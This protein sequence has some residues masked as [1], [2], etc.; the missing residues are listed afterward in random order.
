[1]KIALAQL[2]SIDSIEHN[3][4]EIIRLT[5]EAFAQP[6]VDRPKI[7]FFP[8]NSLYFRIRSDEKLPQIFLDLKEIQVLE[9]LSRDTKIYLHFTSSIFDQGKNWNA[10]VLIAPGEKA[11]II[12]KKI[13]LFDITLNGDKAIRE[14]DVFSHGSEVTNFSINDFKLG[15][16]I[17]YDIRFAE[18]YHKH[19][20][21]QV[22]AIVVPAAFLVK[23]GL[24]HWEVLLKARAIESQCYV[25]APAQWGKHVSLD[26]RSVRETFGHSML[27]NPWG[28]LIAQKKEGVGLIYGDLDKGQC[29]DVRRQIPMSSHRR[30]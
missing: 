18:L 16:S 1:M 2:T 4:K 27:I 12:Y 9:N 29:L 22:D 15:S 17:C 14:S 8:E 7:I 11:K 25:I 10:T 13:H 20:L 6:E 3:A 24:A 19:A 26:G 21:Q 5:Q 23:T 30:V 28:E